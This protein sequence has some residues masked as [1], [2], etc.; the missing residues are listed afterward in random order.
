MKKDKKDKKN[1]I[2]PEKGKNKE[3]TAEELLKLGKQKNFM[4]IAKKNNK[5]D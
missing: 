3:Y 4:N 2:T 5:Y 1:L